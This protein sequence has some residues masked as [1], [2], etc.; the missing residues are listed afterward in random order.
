[1]LTDKIHYAG[2]GLFSSEGIWIHPTRQI[3]TTEIIIMKKGCAAIREEEA[4]FEPGAGSCLRLE[5]RRLH[6]GFRKSADP[7][8]FYWFH[9]TGELPTDFFS[10]EF[11]LPEPYAV[12]VLCR[13]LLHYANTPDYPPEAADCMIRLL[14]LELR[15]QSRTPP[16][17]NRLLGEVCAWIRAHNDRALTSAETA[18]RFGYN[19]DYLSRLFRARY[20]CG[21]KQYL[22]RA[23]MQRIKTLLLS[24]DYTLQQIA[25]MTGFADYKYFLK[26]FTYHEGATPTAYRSL[27][28]NTKTNVR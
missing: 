22:V 2:G 16:E 12:D 20:G 24:P 26:F 25:E 11:Q 28:F 27:Y 19:E 23:R 15:A 21:L 13:Q 6:G 4:F 9:F 10:K 18:A 7:V 3:D 1:M 17:G 5:P 8:S 14:L